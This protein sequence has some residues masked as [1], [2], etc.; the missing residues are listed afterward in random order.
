[1]G[2][3]QRQHLRAPDEVLH[4]LTGQFHRIP[5]DT[6]DAC[7]AGISDLREHVMQ[8]MT[9]LVKKGGDFVVCEKR[10]RAADRCGEI[11]DQLRH[12]DG[13]T[14][15]QRFGDHALVHPRPAAFLDPGVRVEIEA[16]DDAS[17]RVDE[18]V[19][20]HAR[21]PD[22]H[23]GPLAHADAVQPFGHREQSGQH[24]RQRK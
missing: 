14:R 24:L 1:M 20:A 13:F 8:A 3:D 19:V 7:D 6:V 18:I 4:E 11:A 5:S 17:R 22:A 2:G 12:R 16:R 23:P 9:E 10:R 21:V 15:R